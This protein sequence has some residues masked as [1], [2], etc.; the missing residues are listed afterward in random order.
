LAPTLK[1][2]AMES[3]ERCLIDGEKTFDDCIKWAR[4]EFEKRF[5]YQRM[6]LSLFLILI[7]DL[8]SFCF[9]L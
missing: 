9:V 4:I 7:F 1:L 3:L 6:L 8:V 2:S 5:V